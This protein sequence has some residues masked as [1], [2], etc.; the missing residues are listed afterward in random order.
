M[1]R[2]LFRPFKW[3]DIPLSKTGETMQKLLIESTQFSPGLF[4]RLAKAK[5]N[6]DHLPFPPALIES[7]QSI[8][9]RLKVH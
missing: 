5:G 3:A 6:D 7:E 8:R 4:R 1:L 2:N 9:F